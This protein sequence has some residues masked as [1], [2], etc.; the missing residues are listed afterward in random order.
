MGEIIFFSINGA[1]TV[2]YSHRKIPSTLASCK[3]ILI[4]IVDLNIRGE[5]MKLL[6]ENWRK[7]LMTLN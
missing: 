7:I 2:E 4:C 3:I 6:E 1:G 5:T